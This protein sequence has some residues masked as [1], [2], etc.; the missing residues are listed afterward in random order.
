MQSI[1]TEIWINVPAERVWQTLMISRAIPPEIRTAILERKVGCPLKVPMS[2]GGR[3]V[4]LTVTLLTADPHREIRWKGHLWVLGL[5]DGEH[6]FE[7][8]EETE[9]RTLLIQS[10]MFSGLLLPLFSRTLV[11]TRKAFESANTAI[12]DLAEHESE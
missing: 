1:H 3:S 4:T 2:S 11:E 6:K 12:K 8:R 5:F 7:I 10:E 9:G